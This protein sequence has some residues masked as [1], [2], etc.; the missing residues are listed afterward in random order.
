MLPGGA[1]QSQEKQQ[2]KIARSYLILGCKVCSSAKHHPFQGERLA[3]LLECADFPARVCQL[4]ILT[5]KLCEGSVRHKI[6]SST[7]VL[8]QLVLSGRGATRSSFRG[9]Q[10]EVIGATRSS[11]RGGGNMKSL[12]LLNRGTNF[13]QSSQIKFSSYH[14]QKSEIFSFNQNA[15]R[16]IRTEKNSS[17][18][19]TL[20]SVFN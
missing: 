17:L 7:F 4:P 10:Y 19:Q 9:G 5:W 14:L 13:S 8:L 2:H 12:C 15:D 16:T 6:Y 3:Q 11:F 20:D 18:I 1:A